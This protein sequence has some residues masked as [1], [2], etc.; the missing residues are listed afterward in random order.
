MADLFVA[1]DAMRRYRAE[2]FDE[3]LDRAQRG[4]EFD[5]LLAS[6][7]NAPREPAYPGQLPEPEPEAPAPTMRRPDRGPYPGALPTPQGEAHGASTVVDPNAGVTLPPEPVGAGVFPRGGRYLGPSGAGAPRP[8]APSDAAPGAISTRPTPLQD[9]AGAVGGVVQGVTQPVPGVNERLRASVAPVLEPIEQANEAVMGTLG[10]AAE[11]A[12]PAVP[13]GAGRALVEHA[14]GTVLG[15]IGPAPSSVPVAGPVGTKAT[16]MGAAA[17]AKTEAMYGEAA[18]GAA[19]PLARR[20][21]ALGTSL[22][23]KMTDAGVDLSNIEKEAERVL[24]RTLNGDEMASVQSRLNPFYTAKIVVDEAVRPAISGLPR[25]DVASVSKILTWKGNVDVAAAK[26]NAERVFSGGLSAAESQAALQETARRLGPEKFADLERRAQRVVDFNKAELERDVAAG[27]VPRGMADTWLEQYP[28]YT[29]VVVLDYLK[30]QGR[31]LGGSGPSLSVGP[32]GI[33]TLTTAGTARARLDPIAASI[34]AAYQG[35]A[36]RRRNVSFNTFYDLIEK[37]PGF[38]DLFQVQKGGYTG[39]TRFEKTVQGYRNG[40]LHTITTPFEEMAR[41]LKQ[42]DKAVFP[43][44]APAMQLYKELITGRNPTFLVGNAAIDAP[45][46][47]LQ[48]AA[49]EG[50]IQ[51][52]LPVMVDLFRGYADA[53]RG[54][55]SGQYAGE[56]TKG[57]LREGG[58]MGF[59][60]TPTA[61]SGLQEVERL[62]RTSVLAVSTPADALRLVKDLASMEWVKGIGERVE[63]GPR[64]MAYHRALERGLPTEKAVLQGRTV[65][66]DFAQG[67]SLAKILN[68]FI[69]FF[70]PAVQG[71]A[72]TVRIARENPR[73]FLLTAGP[74]LVAPTLAAEAWNR[75]DPERSKAYDDI[76]DYI[77][78]RG[79]VIMLPG[80]PPVDE[81]GEPHPQAIVVNLRQLAPIASLTREVFG[82]VVGVGNHRTAADLLGG[83]VAQVSPVQGVSSFL[84]PVISTAAELQANKNLY[85]GSTIATERADER[86]SAL[87]RGIAGGINTAA[88]QVGEYPQVRPSQ[89]EYAIRDVSGGV[90][91]MTLGASDI[92]AGRT[93]QSGTPQDIPVVGGFARRLVRGDTGQRLQTARDERLDPDVQKALYDA[94]MKPD[95]ATVPAEYHKIPLLRD[96]QARFQSATN[97]H[98]NE[99]LREIVA[100]PG[101]ADLPPEVRQKMVQKMTDSARKIAWAEILDT[102]P[103]EQIDERL[104]RPKKAP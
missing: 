31:A 102:I 7:M 75:A 16:A 100:D 93:K 49:R 9:A 60:A 23:R 58:G 39:G 59:Y 84:P 27:L 56:W 57:F 68:Q 63:L 21:E 28:N 29:P 77:K 8:L 89:A 90:G 66:V 61:K 72:T 94:G 86:A 35:E 40:E 43:G 42:E 32:R 98:L 92:V 62:R 24:G 4:K 70:N 37:T 101:F 91:E 25:R 69:P 76:P 50:G 65:T 48:T 5:D 78:D 73:G 14:G 12:L 81:K 87:S 34:D 64:A 104:S 30:S 82:R 51:H 83:A 44:L 33:K 17:I 80:A 20:L 103:P 3:H 13:A 46:A 47:I 79:V 71:T 26:G 38:E 41:T 19:Q 85:Q 88:A 54:L 97:A 96:E 55:A 53:F 67:G 2:A 22:T 15:M 74:G 1:R 6:K 45:L 10:G 99:L 36:L 95:V 11:Q 52:A 18:R